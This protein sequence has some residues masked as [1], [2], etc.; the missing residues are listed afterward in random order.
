[1]NGTQSKEIQLNYNWNVYKVFKNGNR[2][3]APITTFECEE[4]TVEQY[5]NNII[6]KNF[7]EK[8]ANANYQL[9]RSDMPQH[10]NTLSD[11]E[12]F[13]KE[14]NRDLGRLVSAKKIN[15]KYGIATGLVYCSESNWNWQWSVIESGTGK[16]ISSLSPSFRT[17]READT[18]IKD[19]ISRAET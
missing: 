9:V 15:H 2:A 5:F 4:D 12:K 14:K 7:S 8:F 16:Y 11:E 19:L 10:T 1:M 18:W 17:Y 3:K 6:K 13:L